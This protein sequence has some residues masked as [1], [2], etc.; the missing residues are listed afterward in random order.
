M[1]TRDPAKSKILPYV[2]SKIIYI[3]SEFQFKKQRYF[4]VLDR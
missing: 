3:M 4:A 2:Q 1:Q